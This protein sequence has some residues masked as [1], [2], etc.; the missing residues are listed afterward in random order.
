MN[1]QQLAD[2]VTTKPKMMVKQLQFVRAFM[3]LAADPNNTERVFGMEETLVRLGGHKGHEI[4]MASL[5]RYSGAVEMIEGRYLAPDYKVE[6][7][8]DS[9]PGTLGYAYYRHMTDNGFTPN[10][11]PP[12]KPVNDENYAKLRLRQ[13]HDIWHVVTGYGVDIPGEIALQGFYLGQNP[14]IFPALLVSAGILHVATRQPKLL[15]PLLV[16]FVDGWQRGR[17]ARS[18]WPAHWEEMWHQPLEEVRAEY[19]IT[20]ARSLVAA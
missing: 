12:L 2:K 16:G 6:D 3:S 15:E 14:M 4:F 5:L 1:V 20:P 8:K 11:F 19:G 13:T 17:A 7:L 18:F 10:F 9:T